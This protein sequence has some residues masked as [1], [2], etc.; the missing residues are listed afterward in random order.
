MT[1]R[2]K[3][4]RNYGFGKQLVH[5]GK[6]AVRFRYGDGHHSSIHTH[7]ARWRVAAAFFKEAGIKDAREICLDHV[8]A[9]ARSVALRLEQETISQQYAQNLI[10]TLN[11]VLS[12]LRSDNALEVAPR[13]ILG[14]RSRVRIDAV[15]GVEL[16]VVDQCIS[17]MRHAG[18]HRAAAVTA[19][20]RHGG[21]RLR[22]ACLANL[23]R[24]AS[25][26][27]ARQACNI[28]DG[29]KGGR[30]APRWIPS[31]PQLKAAVENATL[32]LPCQSNNLLLSGETFIQFVRGEVR[33]ARSVLQAHGIKGFHELRAGYACQRYREITGQ[34]PRIN[35]GSAVAA[36]LDAKARETIAYELGH[37]R[38]E[39]ASAYLGGRK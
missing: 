7:T 39:V 1:I 31:T 11:V 38:M 32:L 2:F 33:R 14:I 25:E 17:S 36:S 4:T 29:A 35:G 5:A 37:G 20:A 15:A 6:N 12:T 23:P 10:S 34:L 13:A 18:M 3:S 21:L 8:L 24:L 22:E 30:D 27:A 28:V 9:Y 26:I 19:L 16:E